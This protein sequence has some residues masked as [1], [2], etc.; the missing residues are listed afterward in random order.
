MDRDKRAH[1]HPDPRAGVHEGAPLD[2]LQQGQGRPT[3][4]KVVIQKKEL[5]GD[6]LLRLLNGANLQIPDVD[7]TDDKAW[8]AL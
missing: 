4:P 7:L 5:Y 1:G 8:P 2:P 6:E 3:S